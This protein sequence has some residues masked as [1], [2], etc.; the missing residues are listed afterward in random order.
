M[1]IVLDL[2]VSQP[3]LRLGKHTALLV[4][5]QKCH[6]G[7]CSADLAQTRKRSREGLSPF[8]LFERAEKLCWTGPATP[9]PTPSPSLSAYHA[10]MFRAESH[11]PEEPR[12]QPALRSWLVPQS[13]YP[14]GAAGGGRPMEVPT[15]PCPGP[16]GRRG[17]HALCLPTGCSSKAH[18]PQKCHLGVG[19]RLALVPI[20]L[21]F[22]CCYF[23]GGISP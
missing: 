22:L 16:R 20:R 13:G 2:R 12:C 17:P 5:G 14:V 18:L 19:G 1:K 15:H 10:F 3:D 4:T 11:Q 7:S 6:L 8:A 23:W 9:F 21:D